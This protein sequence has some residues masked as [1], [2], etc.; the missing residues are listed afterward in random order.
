MDRG[1]GAAL[2]IRAPERLAVDGDDVVAELGERGDPGDEAALEGFCIEGREQIA[3]LI[4]RR[5]TMLERR[6]A[7]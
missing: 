2:L 1:F 6:K 4:V 3:E 5:R 7:A